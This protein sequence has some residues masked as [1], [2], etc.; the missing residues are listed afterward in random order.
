MFVIADAPPLPIGALSVLGPV[1]AAALV[2]V[3]AGLRVVRGGGERA[4]LAEAGFFLGLTLVLG[5]YSNFLSIA[6]FQN[7]LPAPPFTTHLDL[8]RKL[9]RPLFCTH[10]GII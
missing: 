5:V 8:A 6:L 1:L 4:K 9:Y 10:L 7:R 3:Y 2:A